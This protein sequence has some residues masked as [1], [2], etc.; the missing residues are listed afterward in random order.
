MTFS[1]RP[2][3]VRWSLVE[4]GLSLLLLGSGLSVHG[5][6]RADS[7][8]VLAPAATPA[9]GP[10]L[11]LR[12]QTVSFSGTIVSGVS[13]GGTLSPGLPGLNTISLRILLPGRR[14]ARGGRVSLVLSMP[15]MAMRP[16]RAT[17]TASSG[18]YHG[19]VAVPMFGRY[20]AQVE[21]ATASGRYT[22]IFGLTLPLA[23][24]SLPTSDTP[25]R[26]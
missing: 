10:R 15:G 26:P 16:V 25:A 3:R 7:Q 11:V 12:R 2:Q 19:R 1:I 24:A 20:R 14:V 13:L 5:M 22:G 6:K 21:A 23:F 18:D 9:V 17:L 8:S 4:F